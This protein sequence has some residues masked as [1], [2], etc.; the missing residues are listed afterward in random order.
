MKSSAGTVIPLKPETTDDLP[1]SLADLCSAVRRF[2]E[3]RAYAEK[4]AGYPCWSAVEWRSVCSPLLVRFPGT[5]QS[6]ADLDVIRVG[7]CTDTGW[8]ARVRWS[9]AEVERRLSETR[10]SLSALTG[11]EVSTADAV[12]VA[13]SDSSLL[14]S[15]LNDLSLLIASRCPAVASGGK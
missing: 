13:T 14:A 3:L 6:L 9:R 1:I 7:T 4:L 11:T 12:S 8:A 10:V 2:D 15:A 5:R